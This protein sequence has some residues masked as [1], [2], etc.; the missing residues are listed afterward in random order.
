ML[1]EQMVQEARRYRLNL[2]RK[3]AACAGYPNPPFEPRT[4]D[5]LVHAVAFYSTPG[6]G[7][8]KRSRR[9]ALAAVKMEKAACETAIAISK[10]RGVPLTGMEQLLAN[11]D[12]D[13]AY[14]VELLGKGKSAKAW[15][16]PARIFGQHVLR[17]LQSADKA[18]G[19]KIRTEFNGRMLALILELLA[20][21]CD[22]NREKLPPSSRAV[23]DALIKRP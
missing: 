9:T 19:R 8:L 23:R 12:A 4:I 16:H 1:K 14:Y 7:D 15:H 18:V 21:V 3:L 11:I 10:R 6:T 5:E 13:I 20:P 22:L 17:V 2:K